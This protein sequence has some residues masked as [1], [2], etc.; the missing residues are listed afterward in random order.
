MQNTAKPRCCKSLATSK[1]FSMNS[2]RPGQTIAEPRAGP[3][4]AGA[5][6]TRTF[7]P[8]RPSSQCSSAPWGTS[9]PGTRTN[10]IGTMPVSAAQ[11]GHDA[12]QLHRDAHVAFDAELPLHE[13]GG[14]I[15]LAARHIDEVFE[16][17]L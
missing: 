7:T 16:L 10:A 5:V 15:E 11:L 13:S 14:R 3:R 6:I 8:P 1:Y 12:L 9:L 2:V 4:V 17:H